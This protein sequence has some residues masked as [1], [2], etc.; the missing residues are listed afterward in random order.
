MI[1][2]YT[3]DKTPVYVGDKLTLNDDEFTI[4]SITE[5]HKPASTGRVNGL[6]EGAGYESSFFPGVI[7]AEWINRE[8]QDGD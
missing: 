7:G 4:T 6:F 2:V 8:D 3:K 1:L 5:P